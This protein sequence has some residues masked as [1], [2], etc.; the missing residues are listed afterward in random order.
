M[1]FNDQKINLLMK[2]FLSIVA[3]FFL[4]ACGSGRVI[5]MGS[6]NSSAC[7]KKYN[8]IIIEEVPSITAV[9]KE[10]S[11][12]FAH[13]L[14]KRLYEVT[15]FQKGDELIL[16]YK[17]VSYNEGSQVARWFLGGIGNAGEGSL[18]VEVTY[19]DKEGN[20]LG[21]IQSEG[22]IGSG[23]FGGSFGHAIDCAVE[24]IANHAARFKENG[25]Q[26]CSVS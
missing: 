2:N 13:S 21:K 12:E 4:T 19:M 23:L 20:E 7:L 16:K 15:K 6:K 25:I 11:E 24:E 10:A 14:A 1:N 18:I 8:S 26:G 9:P 5:E 22:R 17:F 3:I